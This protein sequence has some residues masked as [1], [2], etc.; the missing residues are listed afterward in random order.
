MPPRACSQIIARISGGR[1]S[2][3]E[4]LL[5]RTLAVE[6]SRGNHK[7]QNDQPIE[8]ILRRM[9]ERKKAVFKF[10]ESSEHVRFS[11]TLLDEFFCLR[12]PMVLPRG[13]LAEGVAGHAEGSDD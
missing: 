8:E 4:L 10:S 2:R 11:S 3:G 13:G 9:L 1:D 5:S 6:I 7:K 12:I